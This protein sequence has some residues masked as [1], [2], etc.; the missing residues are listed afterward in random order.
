VFFDTLFSKGTALLM[1]VQE[2]FVLTCLPEAI[3]LLKMAPLRFNIITN[4]QDVN[5]HAFTKAEG[6]RSARLSSM[7]DE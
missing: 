4:S 2:P 6:K 7:L 1:I 3:R 5:F